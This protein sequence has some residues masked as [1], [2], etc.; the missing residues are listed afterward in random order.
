MVQSMAESLVPIEGHLNTLHTK[1]AQVTSCPYCHLTLDKLIF[2]VHLKEHMDPKIG[3]TVTTPEKSKVKDS[4]ADTTLELETPEKPATQTKPDSETT[5]G[6]KPEP[7]KITPEPVKPAPEPEPMK[8][9]SEPGP[10]NSQTVAS[11]E[12]RDPNE[13]ITLDKR[14]VVEPSLS[15][16]SQDAPAEPTK[17]V[18]NTFDG[19]QVET[20]RRR[21]SSPILKTA[22]PPEELAAST[23]P[24]SSFFEKRKTEQ[25]WES[26]P[27]G[28][29]HGYTGPVRRMSGE[30]P[31]ISLSEYTKIHRGRDKQVSGDRLEKTPEPRETMKSPFEHQ[32][33]DLTEA[34]ERE[35]KYSGAELERFSPEKPIFDERPRV[36]SGD[37]IFPRERKLSDQM[38]L[39]KV[40]ETGAEQERKLSGTGALTVPDSRQPSLKP[41]KSPLPEKERGTGKPGEPMRPPTPL[42]RPVTP[43]GAPSPEG[44]SSRSTTPASRP[45][46][47]LDRPASRRPSSDQKQRRLSESYVPKDKPKPV[48]TEEMERQIIY[49]GILLKTKGQVKARD[50]ESDKKSPVESDKRSP[51]E[52]DKKSPA[53]SDKKS[54]AENVGEAFERTEERVESSQEREDRE[55][56]ERRRQEERDKLSREQKLSAVRREIEARFQEEELKRI[57]DKEAQKRKEAEL[58]ERIRIEEEKLRKEKEK[59]AA[60]KKRLKAEKKRA[61]KSKHKRRSSEIEVIELEEEEEKVKPPRDEEVRTEKLSLPPP[62][63]CRAKSRSR[64]PDQYEQLKLNFLSQRKQALE[65]EIRWVNKSFKLLL[66]IIMSIN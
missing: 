23:I 1:E 20:R 3:Q 36:Q 12:T 17:L 50:S 35:R 27:T 52:S 39:T 2:W 32:R 42:D 51:A 33:V 44:G 13:D 26:K 24:F 41:P 65:N 15:P 56:R 48:L 21:P 22:K 64:S 59:I 25:P 53:E 46:T 40:K 14:A 4:S 63:Q 6:C 58:R 60:E 54:P 29:E 19:V 11:V 10:V 62:V 47:P 66:I 37:K 55:R 38:D 28:T 49:G 34:G 16:L 57:Q 31:K 45:T 18:E 7:L 30:K 8:A 5:A 61:R 43:S 9:I